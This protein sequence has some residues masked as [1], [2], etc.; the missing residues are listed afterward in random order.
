VSDPLGYNP[1]AQSAPGL[2]RHD[3]GLPGH[4][5]YTPAPTSSGF[6]PYV[7]TYYAPGRGGS[8][9]YGPP[10]PTARWIARVFAFPIWCAMLPVW[11]ALYPLAGV[12]GLAAGTAAVL[13]LRKFYPATDLSLLISV[14]WMAMLIPAWPVSRFEHRLAARSKLYRYLRHILRLAAA[15]SLVYYASLTAPDNL[16]P[17]VAIVVV[18]MHFLLQASGARA[19]W[20]GFLELLCLRSTENPPTSS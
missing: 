10:S 20:H 7:P 5:A 13:L 19:I 11:G 15:G 8:A 6:T 9:V 16:I 17:I 12:T 4:A 3:A 1:I 18:G 14:A 2:P